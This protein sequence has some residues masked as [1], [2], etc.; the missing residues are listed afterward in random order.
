MRK[1]KLTTL[2]SALSGIAGCGGPAGDLSGGRLA[3]AVRLES[4]GGRPGRVLDLTANVIN[5]IQQL[6]TLL[7]E[8][9]A[10][11]L[12]DKLAEE[13]EHNLRDQG[14]RVPG[15]LKQG[16][17]LKQVSFGYEP[18]REVLHQISINFEAGK[19]YAIV[20]ASGS[21]KS[22]L[23]HLLMAGHSSYTGR[24]AMTGMSCG[25]F[26]RKPCTTWFP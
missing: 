26:K 19:R 25:R 9:G 14:Q 20:G 1:A 23:L 18:D 11:G 4:F 12:I 10:L 5:P 7:A 17:Q 16:I 15:P 8:K 6:P 21:G 24:S 2:L 3:G 22:T 13:M